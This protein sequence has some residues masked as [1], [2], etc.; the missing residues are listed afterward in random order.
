MPNLARLVREGTSG[1]LDTIRP[2]LSPLIWT[3]MMTGVSPLDHGILD[4]V[5]FDP[6]TG[7][8][9]PITSSVRRAPAIWNMASS[10]GKRVA[11]L[12]LWATYP[13]RGDQRHDRVRPSVHVSL[14]GDRAARRRRL[15]R[16]SRRAGRATALA[17]AGRRPWT[18]RRCRHYLPWLS[19][20]RLPRRS[21]ESDD[22][23][24]QPVSAL[25]RI[26]IDTRVY[27]EL[28][29]DVHPARPPGSRDRLLRGHRHHRP[30]LRAVRAAAAAAG[31]AGR[32]R[33]L[34]RRAGALLQADR[35]AT[36]RVPPPRRSVARRADARVGSRVPAGRKAARRRSRATRRRRPRSGTAA[37]GCTCCGARAIGASTGHSGRGS[38]QQ[39]CATLLALLGLPPGRDVEG[40]PLPGVAAPAA[41]ARR[42]LRAVSSRRRAGGE[43]RGRRSRH[44]GEAEIARLRRRR[45]PL[46]EPDRRRDPHARLVQQRGRDSEGAR[47]AGAG[48]RGVRARARAR[49]ESRRRRCGT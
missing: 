43:R 28:G 30:R 39:V 4:F 29:R 34:P 21:A 19:A 37:K 12:G 1:V 18:T 31:L 10:A 24:A 45:R 40:P 6:K 8:K 5:Q 7:A 49:S 48:D 16:R 14:Q 15:S 27:D 32:L 22:P 42:L 33:A 36:R 11:V 3:S 20:R 9:E 35:R 17:R 26:L 23:Y 47:Q 2:P 38:V 13:G 25:R 41:R 46:V 44:A